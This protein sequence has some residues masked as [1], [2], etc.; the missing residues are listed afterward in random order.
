MEPMD[1]LMRDRRPQPPWA[2][3]TAS[4][5]AIGLLLLLGAVASSLLI[6]MIVGIWRG[7]L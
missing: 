4:V 2:T 1:S 5:V 3:R 7:I 6:W